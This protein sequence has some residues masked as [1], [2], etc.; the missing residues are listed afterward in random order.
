MSRNNTSS[1]AAVEAP[2]YAS[3]SLLSSNLEKEDFLI[4]VEAIDPDNGL[5]N[6]DRTMSSTM[7][8]RPLEVEDVISNLEDKGHQTRKL[9]IIEAPVLEVESNEVVNGML[10]EFDYTNVESPPCS[11]CESL[12]ETLHPILKWSCYNDID[13]SNLPSPSQI[14]SIHIYDFDN[15]LFK[16][17][18]PNPKLLNPTSVAMI[19]SPGD[20]NNS[21]WWLEPGFLKYSGKGYDYERQHAWSDNWN[22]DV[23]ALSRMSIKNP[24]VLTIMMTGRKEKYFK[25]LILEMLESKGLIF[26]CCILKKGPNRNT[27]LYK[28]E[29]IQDFLKIYDN[30]SELTIYDDRPFQLTS[31]KKL[32]NQ[33]ISKQLSLNKKIFKYF[34][35]NVEP[36]TK[37][38]HPVIET[39]LIQDLINRHNINLFKGKLNPN[40]QELILRKSMQ[41]TAYI[42]TL[43]S[44]LKLINFCKTKL[45]NFLPLTNSQL[46]KN[47]KFQCEEIRIAKDQISKSVLQRLGGLGTEY[48]FITEF[49][50]S[51]EGKL[52]ILKLAPVLQDRKDLPFQYYDAPY[53][54]IA[55]AKGYHMNPEDILRINNWRS[56]ALETCQINTYVGFNQNLKITQKKNSAKQTT[57]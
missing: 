44:R 23:V 17:P 7:K 41:S 52:Y 56:V 8:K 47:L 24:N 1:E 11:D 38:L 46:F 28:G 4:D 6:F 43:E 51:I 18:T 27:S 35:I 2:V 13:E 39:K 40:T 12:E 30:I 9:D 15:T 50:G 3:S 42:L 26:D 49:Y 34:L 5:S 22:E 14:T 33:H 31:F 53:I 48:N 19:S 10:P 16:T 37:Y 57:A 29:A 20:I 25:K 45:Q 21:Y 54:V 36:K 32:L 55:A